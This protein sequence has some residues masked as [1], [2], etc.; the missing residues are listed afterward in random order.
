MSPDLRTVLR[1]ALELAARSGG[2]FDP[3]VGGPVAALGF[4]PPQAPSER[5]ASWRDV[6][7]TRRG[8]RFAKPLVLDFGG[9]AKGFAVDCAIDALRRH[10][11]VSGSRQRRWRFAR[12]R[13]P[14]QGN[15]CPN[16]RSARH[17]LAA[18]GDRRW[19]SGYQRVRWTAA[20]HRRAL[21]NAA[22]RSARP[23]ADDEHAN[24][25][26]GGVHVHGGGRADQSRRIARCRGGEC[27]DGLRRECNDALAGRRPLA[28]HAVARPTTRAAAAARDCAFARILLRP[29]RGLHAPDHRYMSRSHERAYRLLAERVRLGVP[30][31][32]TLYA[33]VAALI[34]SGVWWLGV[35]Y[36]ESL[37]AARTDDLHRLAQ[38][39]LALKVHGATAIAALLA[40]G[41]MG[42]RHARR[43]W[44]LNRNRVSRIGGHRRVHVADRDRL[45]L[46]LSCER[47]H[48]CAGLGVALGIGARPGADADRAH[49][50]WPPRSWL[51]TR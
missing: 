43:G 49:R 44:V 41:A 16:R 7:L 6:H 15:S 11:I 13:R 25:I 27:A 4:L 31:R 38:E 26:G 39:A 36:S 9:I 33:T 3:T 19:R 47:R 1:C 21:G 17:R 2:T 45:C 23:A 22:D 29:S 51:R 12:L 40:L 5:D 20:V 10:R 35:H 32:R 50:R 28:M 37:F 34:G 14:K 24:G 18:G 42:A 46:V 48:A 30:A 8:V